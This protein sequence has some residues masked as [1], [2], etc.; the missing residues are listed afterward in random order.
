MKN[1]NTSVTEIT[2]TL[3]AIHE[4][5]RKLYKLESVA[6]ALVTLGI[7]AG[8][9]IYDSVAEIL[10]LSKCASESVCR[11]S[12]ERLQEAQEFN[13]KLLSN[14]FDKSLAK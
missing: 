2:D 9:D 13:A 14:F 1:Y 10:H 7:P 8:E 4:I 3:E 5:Q 6:S 12:N 11:D